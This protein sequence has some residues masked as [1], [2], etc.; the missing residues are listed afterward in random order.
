M[1][2]MATPIDQNDMMKSTT[3]TAIPAKLMCVNHVVPVEAGGSGRLLRERRST[4]RQQA[5]TGT[6]NLSHLTTFH[7]CIL[8]NRGRQKTSSAVSSA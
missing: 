2:S 4:H 3:A 6:H 1:R 7:Y 5:E 8:R